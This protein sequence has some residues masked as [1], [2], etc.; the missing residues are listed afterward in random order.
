MTGRRW[1]VLTSRRRRLAK[2]CDDNV[3]SKN[4]R[5]GCRMKIAFLAADRFEQVELTEPWSSRR[6]GLG[7]P[8]RKSE[9]RHDHGCQSP[10]PG[11][12]VRCDRI[13]GELS[14]DDYDALVIPGGVANPDVLRT[15]ARAV[16]FVRTF[17]EQGKPVA[18]QLPGPWMLVEADVVRA[19]TSRP[20]RA[21]KRTSA[22]PAAT[23]AMSPSSSTTGS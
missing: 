22:T 1:I 20:G 8:A 2:G 7:A 6:A 13:L 17:V 14:A 23:G 19:A 11:R 5:G 10:R 4:S 15:D 21:W 16:D 18:G 9:A 3:H 12:H